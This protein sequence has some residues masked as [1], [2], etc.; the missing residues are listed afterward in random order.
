MTEPSPSAGELHRPG[1]PPGPDRRLL[2]L[3]LALVL[4][5]AVLFAPLPLEPRAQRLAAIFLGV[6]IC[7][8]TEA[9]PIAATALLIAPLMVLFG[10]TDPTT[11]FAPYADPL[12]FIFV[13]GFFIARAMTLHGLDRRIA[14]RLLSLPGIA[15]SS[16]RTQGALVLAGVV[17]S[18]WISNTATSA[19]LVPIT[20]GAFR[21]KAAEPAV[22]TVAYACSL[23]GLG[24]LVGS[25]PNLI[26]VRFLQDAGVDIGFVDWM[27]VGLPMAVLGAA[28]VLVVL[29]AR[30]EARGEGRATGE[31]PDAHLRPWSRGERV[32]AVAFAA[33]VIGWVVPGV[34]DAVGGPGAAFLQASTPEG[35]TF[36]RLPV[37]A[38]ALLAAAILFLSRVEAQEDGRRPRVLPWEEANRIDWGIVMLFGGGI[39]L[40]RQ[41]FETG[42]AEALARGFVAATGVEGLWLLTALVTVFTIFF[43][44]VCSNTASA[45]MLAPLVIAVAQELDVS[46]VPPALAVGLAAS[47]AFMLPI[48]TGPNAI[49]YGSGVVPLP[50]MMRAGLGLNLLSGGL[51][52]LLLRVLCP[53]FGWA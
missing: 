28:L 49:A 7:W 34:L 30:A 39:S 14:H 8:V 47:C 38:V 36:D 46:P 43:T 9:L 40:G 25:P 37:G 22:L 2:G 19:I 33:A 52:F 51:V 41:M 35:G 15:G 11:A 1:N 16:R 3:G 32:T 5:T 6:V 13:G 48:A 4:G 27:G 42:L 17:L 10:V 18:M 44:E 29:R 31:T 20:L 53:L 45:N 21:G 23:G 26:T 50:A 24:T 12:L